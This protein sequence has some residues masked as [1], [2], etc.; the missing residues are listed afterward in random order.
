MRVFNTFV[1][2]IQFSRK[3]NMKK[4]KKNGANMLIGK[5]TVTGTYPC[6]A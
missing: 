1:Y 4:K 6:R 3:Q 2:R 5:Q